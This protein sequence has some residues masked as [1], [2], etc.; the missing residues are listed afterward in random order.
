VTD[1]AD[2]A[3]FGGGMNERDQLREA[4]RYIS[5]L[6]AERDRYRA[7]LERIDQSWS[8][9]HGEDPEQVWKYLVDIAREVLYPRSVNSGG[10]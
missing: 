1:Q 4:A 8:V 2:D 7:A 3:P 5:R 6:E 9:Q 10:F